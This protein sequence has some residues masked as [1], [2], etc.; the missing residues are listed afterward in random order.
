MMKRLL[1]VCLSVVM[2]VA[3]MS[4]M[5]LTASAFAK[6]DLNND[7][8][9]DTLD[10]RL[11]MRAALGAVSVTAQQMHAGDMNP[12]SALTT[13]DAQAL[14]RLLLRSDSSEVRHVE[15]A[16][17]DSTDEWGER[18]IALIGDSMSYGAWAQDAL[19]EHSYVSFVK[20]A[21]QKAN[22]GNMNYGFVSANPQIWTQNT[23]GTFESFEIHKKVSSTNWDSSVKSGDRLFFYGY[24]S[25]TPAAQLTYRLRTAYVNSYDYFC[26]YYQAQPGGGTFCL[27]DMSGND[28]A[29]VT[30]DNSYIDT[31]SSESVT[32]R[33]ALYPLDA[34][35][36]DSGCPLI[37]IYH[38]TSGKPVT[39][40]G[41]GYYKNQSADTV[42][43]NSFSL[44]EQK[45]GDVSDRVLD[46]AASA[47][48]LIVAMGYNDAYYG[49][50]NVNNGTFA[51]KID[52][53]I[54]VCNENGTNVIVTDHVWSNPDKIAVPA[55][56]A[57]V[58]SELRRL[59]K[60]TGGIYIDQQALNPELIDTL[61][62]SAINGNKPGDGIH[63]NDE[64]HRIIAQNIIEAMGLEWTESWT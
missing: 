47:D 34:C 7:S 54:A 6:G 20:K 58:K 55:V 36:K 51:A 56:Q 43:F 39:I 64:G 42:T 15:H 45:L 1:A 24:T 59:A 61:N 35:A 11:I 29:D 46:Q 17:P 18:S 2:L 30:G 27:T 16:Y 9:V 26:V 23:A 4:V 14:M 13:S 57:T 8:R 25:S 53:L 50:G 63:P 37:S 44:S 21:V 62:G 22:D 19:P 3:M 40:T 49:A 28:I 12:D 38:D 5:P 10:V 32:M 48:T 60:E 41:I 52:H 33:T 31:A